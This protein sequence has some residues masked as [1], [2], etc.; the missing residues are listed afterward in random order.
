MSFPHQSVLLNEV[1][2]LFKDKQL[3]IFID[4]TL[5]AGGHSIELLKGHPEVK[6]W[7]G[8]D[9]DIDA[10]NIAKER[11]KD[12]PVE[13]KNVNFSQATLPNTDG[14]LA[15]LG[16]SSMQFDQ[17]EKGFSFR[18]EGPLDMRMDRRRELTAEIIVNEWEEKELVRIFKEYG[19][20]QKAKFAARAI[21]KGRPFY[22]TTELHDCLQKVLY[23]PRS[24][25]N[26]ATKVFQ[27]LRIAVN[28][29]LEVIKQFIPKAIA[30][31][32]KG[33]RLAI[34]TFHSLED[35]IVKQSFQDLASDKVTTSGLGGLFLEKE[36]LVKLI[37]KGIGPTEE[38]IR[39]NPRA[40]SARLRCV[41][42]L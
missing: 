28:D 12:F 30:A 22:T 9:Q 26:P 14:I 17:A 36:P 3:K 42:K 27:A 34:I 21:I 16:V 18:F 8:I 11:L 13:Y 25:I 37:N 20:E 5:G 6:K 31:L 24:K 40:R 41:E 15:D 33:G 2:D 23:N 10:L 32:N 35:R 38:E 19:E 4:A 1:V 7:I 39:L 29:E